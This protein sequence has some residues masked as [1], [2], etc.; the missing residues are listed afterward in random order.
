MTAENTIRPDWS[1]PL[2]E[3]ADLCTLCTQRG[4]F[5]IEPVAADTSLP[6]IDAAD[7]PLVFRE[8]CLVRTANRVFRIEEEGFYRFSVFPDTIHNR[9]FFAAD[10]PRLVGSITQLH[11]HGWRHN[12]LTFDELRAKALNFRLSLACGFITGFALN[13]LPTLG[14]NA[15]AVSLFTLEGWN[16]YSCGHTLYEYFD[17][18]SRRWLLA[19]S[20]FGAMFRVDGEWLDAMT[21]CHLVRQGRQIEIVPVTTCVSLDLSTD[22]VSH[23]VAF[24]AQ[25]MGFLNEAGQ[26]SEFVRRCFQVPTIGQDCTMD[27]PHE[28]E[29]F[30]ALCSTYDN[31]RYN[32]LTPEQ[33]QAKYYHS[34]K[35]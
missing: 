9:I 6:I 27:T 33:F 19:D 14:I 3:D 23:Q 35:D 11:V 25:A 32:Y 18:A 10:I 17:P 2:R 20:D 34:S 8:P 7:L 30:D 29:R 5:K 26:T 28:R 1:G 13:L 21:A 4:V 22:G 31:L 16:S 15:R 12:T 24:W